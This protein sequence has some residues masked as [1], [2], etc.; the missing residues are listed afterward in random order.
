M[1]RISHKNVT[2]EFI[3]WVIVTYPILVMYSFYGIKLEYASIALGTLLVVLDW[4]N[5]KKILTVNYTILIF[6]AYMILIPSIIYVSFFNPNGTFLQTGTIFFF[7]IL[8]LGTNYTQKKLLWKAYFA[9]LWVA[10]IIFLIQE[11]LWYS[12]G[13]RFS[14]LIP[15]LDF[16]YY[17]EIGSTEMAEMQKLTNRSCS[18][19][20]EPAVFA[21]F[22]IPTV[23]YNLNFTRKGNLRIFGIIVLLLLLRSGVGFMLIGICVLIYLCKMPL[24]NRIL[25]IVAISSIVVII[26]GGGAVLA[27]TEYGSK[28]FERT[29]EFDSDNDQT[30][31][32]V[33]M[34]RG[35]FLYSGMSTAEKITGV[36]S[37]N[38]GCVIET[39]PFSYFFDGKDD[40]YLNGIQA[41]LVG[42]GII[43]LILFYW[44]LI[45]NM[46]W[47]LTINFTLLLCTG[48]MMFFAAEYLSA[49]MVLYFILAIAEIKD[50]K[51]R[52][53]YEL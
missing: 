38:I 11:L 26:V 49:T 27:S 21:K 1:P 31:G 47:N 16:T 22:L 3:S 42:G 25:K 8:Y 7:L 43:G 24:K 36:G 50:Y 18:I 14:A 10:I 40:V 19:F 12:T 41:L 13:S 9:V 17:S 45:K 44:M 35:F 23:I 28:I 34:F 4:T 6:F 46:R 51:K 53:V 33:R 39:S 15:G 30:S 52:L 29:E 48:I 20:M 5:K 32:F 37:K 2:Y